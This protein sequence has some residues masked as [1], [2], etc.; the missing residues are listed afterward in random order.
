V[1]SAPFNILRKNCDGIFSEFL[2]FKPR[3]NGK[4]TKSELKKCRAYIAF[5][6]AEIEH[7]LESLADRALDRALGRWKRNGTVTKATGALLVYRHFTEIII[8]EDPTQLIERNR[9]NQIIHRVVAT[10]KREVRLNHGIKRKNI[11]QLFI[12]IGLDPDSVPAPLYI[13]LDGLG[14]RRGDLVHTSESVSLPKLRDPFSDE[15]KDV[16]QLISELLAFDPV[17]ASL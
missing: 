9:L 15:A 3:I 16:A 12:P 7:Y 2:N 8:P 1:P 4:Y 6:H 10:Q 11:G 5:T 13:Q 17:L 14:A